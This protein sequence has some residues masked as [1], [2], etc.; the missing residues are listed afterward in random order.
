MTKRQQGFAGGYSTGI[1]TICKGELHSVKVIG[2][3]STL[4]AETAAASLPGNVG[5]IH[6]RSRGGGGVGW[7]HPFV[8]GAKRMA[9]LA[10]GDI[11]LFQDQ[12]C[13]DRI[14]RQL[15]L[16]GHEFYSRVTGDAAEF[17]AKKLEK[18]IR[19]LTA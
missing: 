10:N 12:W 16:Q 18:K 1:A 19:Q 5:I 9:Y 2:D 17:R 8:D 13:S 4:I 7:A 6:S 11:G 15:A 3:V 14:A